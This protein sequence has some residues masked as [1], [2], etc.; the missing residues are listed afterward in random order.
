MSPG[1]Q[2]VTWPLRK[3]R[4][5]GLGGI[6]VSAEGLEGTPRLS[7]NSDLK[8]SR[9]HEMRIYLD[10]MKAMYSNALMQN[11]EIYDI[12]AKLTKNFKVIRPEAILEDSRIIRILRYAMAPSIS[13]MK[14][15]Q[16]F[17]LHSINKF[18]NDRVAPGSTKHRKLRRIAP[19]IASFANENLDHK[20]FLWLDKGLKVVRNLR[21][22][23]EYAKNWT[24]SIAADQNAQTRYRNWRKD[25]QEHAIASVL[26]K[27]GYTKSTYSGIV[28]RQTDIHLGEY[29]QEMRVQGRT[30]QKADLV[31]RSKTTKRLVLIEAK[32][33]GVEIDSTKRIK[34]CCD[35]A[36]D[37][38]SSRRLNKPVI[39]AAIAGFFN[40]T[41]IEN[42]IAS[43][44]QVVWEHRLSVLKKVL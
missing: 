27:I 17:G 22:A 16:F 13:Q 20:R 37:W 3:P 5:G 39:V 35:K 38:R 31:V 19:K 15:G 12:A 1:R 6:I 32:A 4:K 24:C 40:S 7:I 18:E 9:E 36:N 34:E 23:R 33:V 43:D 30:R 25:Q 44:I 41:G 10:S 42:L 11:G 28:T 14:F 2:G 29:T 26:V 8:R 21:L